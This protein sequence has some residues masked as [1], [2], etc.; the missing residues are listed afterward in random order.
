M[1]ATVITG[2]DPGQSGGIAHLVAGVL[3]VIP[4]PWITN[5]GID[6]PTLKTFLAC[7]SHVFMEQVQVRP[8]QGVGG[9]KTSLTQWG[10]CHGII[11]GMDIPLELVH[12]QTW[13]KEM[14]CRIPQGGTP[15]AR[16]KALKARSVVRARQIWPRER[17][18]PTPK[19]KV[20]NDGMAEAALIAEYGRRKLAGQ[21]WKFMNGA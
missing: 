19:C 21:T 5:E 6:G 10:R 8:G 17:F 18:L 1:S 9:L 13:R 2:I 7:S 11:E 16:T 20:P 4:M 3:E 15:Y 14:D 12:P